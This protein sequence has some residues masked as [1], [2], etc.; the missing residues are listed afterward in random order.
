METTI[1]ESRTTLLKLEIVC[2]ALQKSPAFSGK[3]KEVVTSANQAPSFYMDLFYM[4]EEEGCKE[5]A[6]MKDCL[7][8]TLQ[9]LLQQPT[10]ELGAITEA[11]RC[12]LMV[13]ESKEE[14]YHWV[15][16]LIQISKTISDPATLSPS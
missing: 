7:R 2:L 16:Q 1:N 14:E 8:T 15:E 11:I 5:N 4:L 12:L 9:L 3:V 6:A 10:V 13:C